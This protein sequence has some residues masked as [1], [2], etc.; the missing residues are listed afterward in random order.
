MTSLGTLQERRDGDPD[1][2]EDGFQIERT[3]APWT[4][5]AWVLGIVVSVLITYNA[6]ANT[7]RD[8]VSE[9]RR[10]IAVLEQAKRDGDRRLDDLQE[11]VG[12]LNTKID[13][14]IKI[15]LNEHRQ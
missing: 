15:L 12:K 10:R 4:A 6:T 1:R 7:I 8:Q 11:S 2:R 13:D 5:V 14:L 3:R 9:N